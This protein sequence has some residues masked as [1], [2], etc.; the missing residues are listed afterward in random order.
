MSKVKFISYNG[1]YP[2]LCAGTLVLEIKGNR[3][4]LENVLSSGGAC[5]ID[6]DYNELIEKGAWSV[7]VPEE[8]QQ[9]TEEITDLVNENV[10]LGCCG[11]CL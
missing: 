5:F 1:E 9:Y 11:G 2:N 4:E 3:V 7:N 6:N 10:P 8:Y